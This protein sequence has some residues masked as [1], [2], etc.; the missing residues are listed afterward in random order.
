MP[1]LEK[2][3]E[4]LCIELSWVFV[5]LETWKLNPTHLTL[6]PC[7]CYYYGV[8]SVFNFIVYRILFF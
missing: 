4:P 5:R 7:Q 2:K 8:I 3:L 6:V 1:K